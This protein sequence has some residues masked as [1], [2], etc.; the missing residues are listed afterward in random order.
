[1]LANRLSSPPAIQ[2][3]TPDSPESKT[4]EKRVVHILN[5]GAAPQNDYATS[6]AASVLEACLMFAR[7]FRLRSL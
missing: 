5:A 3:D 1:M 7:L 2:F 4:I 6:F